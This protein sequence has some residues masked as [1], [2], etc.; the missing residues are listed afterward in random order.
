MAKIIPQKTRFLVI[1]LNEFA[2]GGLLRPHTNSF[3][4]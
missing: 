4:G 2:S 1:G 3:T